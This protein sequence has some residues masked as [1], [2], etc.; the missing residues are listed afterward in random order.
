MFDAFYTGASIGAFFLGIYVPI[1]LYRNL[2]AI[3]KS[4]RAIQTV[5]Y[6]QETG[7]YERITQK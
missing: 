3:W 5:K 1:A 6:N 4:L 7:Q 2:P